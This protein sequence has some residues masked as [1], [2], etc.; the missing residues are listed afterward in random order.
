[1]FRIDEH[2]LLLEIDG[3]VDVEFRFGSMPRSSLIFFVLF[4]RTVEWGGVGG[5]GT[6]CVREIGVWAGEGRVDLRSST[7]GGRGGTEGSEG[8]GR[9][10]EGGGRGERAESAAGGRREEKGDHPAG[11]RDGREEGGGRKG[12]RKEGRR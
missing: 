12:G 1:M 2:N 7:E 9:G 6:G 3:S 4:A 11:E 8:G 10:E 5:E